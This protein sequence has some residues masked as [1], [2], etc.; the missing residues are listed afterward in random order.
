MKISAQEECGIRCLLRIGRCG[1]GASLTIPEISRAEGLSTHYVAKL[2]RILRRGGLV[3]SVR[4]QA[5]GYSLARPLG[6]ITV[7]EVLAV[8]GGRLYDPAFCRHHG[9][10]GTA[11]ADTTD[12]SIRTLWRTV[13]EAVDQVLASAT[14]AD[15][16][17]K[18]PPPG[19]PSDN[20]VP[21][22]TLRVN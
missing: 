6:Q 17:P 4:G 16:L 8:L 10:G 2:T 9:G 5:G 12:C 19:P 3:R 11:C 13:Q 21:L 20:A 22:T 15:L 7:N 1:P 18:D 14:L